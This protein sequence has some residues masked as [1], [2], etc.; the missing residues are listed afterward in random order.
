M[1]GATEPLYSVCHGRDIATKHVIKQLD[2]SVMAKTFG[3]GYEQDTNGWFV[4][5]RGDSERRRYWPREHT[6]HPA[7]M[8]IPLFLGI[9]QYVSEPGQTILDPFGGIGTTAIATLHGRKVFLCEVEGSFADIAQSAYDSW[10]E[11]KEPLV[12]VRGDNRR[13]LPIP[14]DHI[15]TSP[16][17]ANTMK[18]VSRMKGDSM[19]LYEERMTE[20]QEMYKSSALNIGN[21]NPFAYK[22][23]MDKVY[24]GCFESLSSGGTMTVVLKDQ[25][26][27]GNRVFLSKA[28]LAT[29]LDIGFRYREWFKHKPQESALVHTHKKQGKNPILD[30][31]I[32]VVEKP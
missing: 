24:K 23:A 1:S 16:P 8:P 3:T 21:A 15:I 27:A 29:L 19:K 20:G 9:M 4:F 30:E 18:A 22:Y 14:C 32:I 26:Q 7:K 11:P 28:C 6:L 13:T 12:I 25:M 17:Y 5:G 2:G 31:D 10:P